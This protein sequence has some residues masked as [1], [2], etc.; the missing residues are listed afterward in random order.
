MPEIDGEDTQAAKGPERIVNGFYSRPA[1]ALRIVFETCL[2]NVRRATS[3]L[4]SLRYERSFQSQGWTYPALIATLLFLVAALATPASAQSK[5]DWTLGV[6]VHTVAPKSNS[7]TLDGSAMG[8]GS[9]RA[10][11]DP[12]TKP[13]FTLE[14]FFADNWGIEAL[15]AWP[16]KHDIKI[17]GM[18]RVGSTQQVTPVVS[19]Q[20]HFANG[21]KLTPFLGAGVSF[22]KFFNTEGKGALEGADLKLEDRF[23]VALHAG[24]DYA[25]SENGSLRADVRWAKIGTEVGVSGNDLGKATVDPLVYGFAYVHKF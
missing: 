11:V 9:L 24:L 4:F 22:T 8:L 10:H 25:I 16:F 1:P 13:T 14:Y 20:Y 12:D 18:G 23:G 5:G 21:S 7:G 2:F 19:I 3:A 15:G 17:D 6:G